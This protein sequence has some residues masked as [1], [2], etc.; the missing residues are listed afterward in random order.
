VVRHVVTYHTALPAENLT[1]AAV[2][3]SQAAPRTD[4][5]LHQAAFAIIIT[6]AA[7]ITTA[8]TSVSHTGNSR[9]QLNTREPTVRW[10]R[11]SPTQMLLLLLKRRRRMMQARCKQLHRP[12]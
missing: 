7:T 12:R 9:R 1:H 6:P 4:A 8:D 10:K 5:G 3:T 2:L 11:L